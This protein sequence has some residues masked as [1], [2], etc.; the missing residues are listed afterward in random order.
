MNDRQVA[1]DACDGAQKERFTKLASVYVES[2]ELAEGKSNA[3]AE[4]ASAGERF[5]AGLKLVK[6]AHESSRAIVE[7]VFP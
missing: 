5:K 2:F 1:L 3:D 6:A 4:R 7:H